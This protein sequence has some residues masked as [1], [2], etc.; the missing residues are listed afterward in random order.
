LLRWS[1]I[2]A[3]TG[4]V[5]GCLAEALTRV[6]PTLHNLLQQPL[7]FAAFAVILGGTL[8]SLNLWCGQ[9]PRPERRSFVIAVVVSG[10]VCGVSG[11]IAIRFGWWNGP[12]FQMSWASFGTIYWLGGMGYFAAVLLPH[13]RLTS[14][15]N[16]WGR[17]FYFVGVL[18][19]IATATYVG[20]ELCIRKGVYAFGGGYKVWHDVV[21]GLAIFCA[22]FI[23][24][25]IL[26]PKTSTAH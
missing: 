9:P 2:A 7:A 24:Y 25:E 22:P 11:V 20:D 21:Y 3:T 14:H 23:V 15:G 19:F 5:I 26:R 4:L 17:I 6:P 8:L 18:T 1:S 13:R 12:A 10:I 16:R